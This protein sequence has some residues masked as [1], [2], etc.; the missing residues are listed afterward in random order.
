KA[1]SHRKALP[2]GDVATCIQ[3][4]KASGA[5]RSTKLALE[6][7]I[8]TAARSGEVRNA[9]WDE[10]SFGDSP[11]ANSANS[12]KQAEWII[13]A[14]RMKMK[15]EHRVPLCTRA[16]EILHE[17]RDLSDGGNLVFVGTKEG[18]PLSDMTLSKLVKELGFDVDVHG[19]R[20]SFRTWAQE[21]TSVARE[22][23]EAALAHSIKDASE[24]AYARSDLFEKRRALMD[25]WAAYLAE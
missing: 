15:R 16:V 2:Y 4:I 13:P 12:A 10:F 8:L 5:G 3:V 6:F 25:D 19:F 21:Q 14:K 22:V 18:K 24:A 20:T 7:L 23:A 17:V 9:T 1:V 11:T